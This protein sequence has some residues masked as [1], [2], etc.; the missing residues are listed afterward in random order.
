MLFGLSSRNDII[1]LADEYI[2]ENDKPCQQ[3]IDLSLS[4]NDNEIDFM[5]KLSHFTVSGIYFRDVH[6][7]VTELWMLK[8]HDGHLNLMQALN[9][10]YYEYR[11][12]G[13]RLIAG[14]YISLD[15]YLNCEPEFHKDSEI[16][17]AINNF[18]YEGRHVDDFL[19]KQ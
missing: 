2:I 8:K 11:P 6:E 7:C 3:V 14:L 19:F 16:S 18:I 5:N 4:T 10:I 17:L 1:A 12:D 13:K 9:C 15:L